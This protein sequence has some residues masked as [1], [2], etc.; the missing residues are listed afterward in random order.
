MKTKVV[1]PVPRIIFNVFKVF[2]V[3]SFQVF[4]VFKVFRFPAPVWLSDI[5]CMTTFL[6][7][8]KMNNSV[9]VI[10]CRMRTKVLTRISSRAQGSGNC[11]SSWS[12]PHSWSTFPI[13]NSRLI[14]IDPNEILKNQ[15][16]TFWKKTHLSFTSDKSAFCR[17]H[18]Y[19]ACQP[20]P[21]SL[22]LSVW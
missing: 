9:K 13:N 7:F 11:N 15:Y 8:P 2:K 5:F 3:S 16:F 14:S 1:Q 17:W 4:K 12:H 21:L 20:F 18:F 22:S 10:L 6:Q 19:F